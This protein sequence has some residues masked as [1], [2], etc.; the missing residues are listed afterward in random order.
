MGAFVKKLTLSEIRVIAESLRGAILEASYGKYEE[1]LLA[2]EAHK[3]IEELLG[4]I[5]AIEGVKI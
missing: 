1:R 4:H 2:K 3:D 5:S